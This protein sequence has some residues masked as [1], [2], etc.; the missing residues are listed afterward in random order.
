[1]QVLASLFGPPQVAG[2]IRGRA[3]VHQQV[4]GAAKVKLM[5]SG[6]EE[7][8]TDEKGTEEKAPQGAAANGPEAP[9][10][11]Q[12]HAP[13]LPLVSE[14][15]APAPAADTWVTKQEAAAT[16]KAPQH[17]LG[18]AHAPAPAAPAPAKEPPAETD[19]SFSTPAQAHTHA[20]EPAFGAP[21]A[22]KEESAAAAYGEEEAA[23]A[24]GGKAGVGEDA[25]FDV[26][27]VRAR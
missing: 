24:A 27:E 14:K 9:P 10:A 1:M 20:A 6:T 15:V 25:S 7:K 11:G 17:E 16:E 13:P 5:S 8:G 4:D 3:A 21:P 19:F 18:L 2:V 12:L 23:A 26:D 22:R